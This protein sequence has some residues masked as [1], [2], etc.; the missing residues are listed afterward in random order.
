[1]A[2]VAPG[3]KQMAGKGQKQMAVKGDIIVVGAGPVGL[4]AALLLAKDGHKVVVY[5]GR[6]E[7]PTNIEDSYPIGIN[8][9]ALHC[10]RDIDPEL[11]QQAI[12]EGRIIDSWQIFGG[13]KMVAEA[14]SGTVYGT[15]RGGLNMLLYNYAVSK[16]ENVSILFNHKLKGVKF[17]TK[18]LIFDVYQNGSKQ[19]VVVAG[20]QARVIAAD[21]VHSAVRR[22]MEGPGFVKS[23]VT[24]WHSEFRV[25]FAKRGATSE[26]L[27]PGVHYI[28]SGCYTAIV[29]VGGVE[30]WTAVASC[31]DTAS[32]EERRLLLSDEASVE[33]VAALRVYMEK[34]AG[35]IAPIIDD[36]ELKRFFTRRSYRGAVVKVNTVQ[37]REWIL[38]LGDAAHSVLPPTGEGVNSGLEDCYVLSC[39]MRV[40]PGSPFAA[41][42]KRRLGDLHGLHQIATYLNDGLAASGPEAGSRLMVMIMQSLLK[43]CGVISNT[44]EDHFFGPQAIERKPYGEIAESWKQQLA[45]LLPFSRC[46]CYSCHFGFCCCL[47]CPAKKVFLFSEELKPP[48]GR[49]KL[50][51]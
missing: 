28:F 40:S 30:S 1:M 25:L 18:E 51:E 24:P 21:G 4:A 41:Y 27:D 39:V 2:S 47:C 23:E 11:E 45:C 6:P 49:M 32:D 43:K 37:H 48:D 8:P 34:T 36:D 5:E 16:L 26:K 7:I 13:E 14:K 33:N 22:A 44:S 17:E 15:T 12:E 10:L 35:R 19:E 31:K 50:L 38:L 46:C 29:K 9:R 20:G 3:Q 42:E